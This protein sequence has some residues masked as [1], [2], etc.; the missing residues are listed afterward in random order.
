MVNGILI[1]VFNSFII[2][3][4]MA[5]ALSLHDYFYIRKKIQKTKK[6]FVDE[7]EYSKSIRIS[8]LQKE[9]NIN[10]VSICGALLFIFVMV[11]SLLSL[12]H[13]IK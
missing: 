11:M 3:G 13:Y 1:A 7:P 2:A 6:C 5:L 4:T 12:L 10:I 9:L 8:F